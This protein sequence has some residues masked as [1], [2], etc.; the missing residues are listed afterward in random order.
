MGRFGFWQSYGYDW[1]LCLC[2]IHW[3]NEVASATAAASAALSA[4]RS[5]VSGTGPASHG[6]HGGHE[7]QT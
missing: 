5:S 1:S 7:A 6:A 3:A 4:G 2:E